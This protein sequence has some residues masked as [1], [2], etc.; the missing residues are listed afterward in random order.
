MKASDEMTPSPEHPTPSAE[1]NVVPGMESMFAEARTQ[2]LWF[3]TNYQQLWFS[4][5]ELEQHQRA[6]TFR[7]GAVNWR[8]RP[9]QEYLEQLKREA[10]CARADYE[11]GA[12]RVAAAIRQQGKETEG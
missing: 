1:M 9:P 2:G 3:F 5:D 7:W 4:P 6:G 12:A 8:L 10:G 11:R